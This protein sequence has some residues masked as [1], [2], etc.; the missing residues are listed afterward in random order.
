METK[1]LSCEQAVRL[2]F[3]YLDRALSGEDIEALETHLQACLDCCEK[4]EFSRKLDAFVK[5][6]ITEAPLPPGIQE[7]IKRAV[8]L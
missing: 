5:A 6:R 4:L 2:F 8:G 1:P 7:R 3:S